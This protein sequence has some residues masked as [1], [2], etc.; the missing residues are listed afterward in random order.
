MSD[1]HNRADA[2]AGELIQL[3]REV[4]LAGDDPLN[5]RLKQA[6]RILRSAGGHSFSENA[7]DRLRER[8]ADELYGQV[9]AEDLVIQERK[10]NLHAIVRA[11]VVRELEDERSAVRESAARVDQ[12]A[13]YVTARERK[14]SASY[15][16]AFFTAGAFLTLSADVLVR[17]GG[18]MLLLLVAGVRMGASPVGQQKPPTLPL[19]GVGQ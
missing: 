13:D 2:L 6:T 11:Q 10:E 8:I 16:A 9:A 1:L 12:R 17:G 4:A 15:R 19:L 18:L 5:A 14:A 3:K 7:Y